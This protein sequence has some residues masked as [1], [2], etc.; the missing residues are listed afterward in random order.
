MPKPVTRPSFHSSS[1]V[2]PA[3]PAGGLSCA[4][5]N[6]GDKKNKAGTILLYM[7]NDFACGNLQLLNFVML[8]V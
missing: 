4:M 7:I 2:I 8:T 6:K 5:T 3:L 1:G